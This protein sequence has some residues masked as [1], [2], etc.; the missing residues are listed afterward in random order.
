MTLSFDD[1]LTFCHS[2]PYSIWDET[3]NANLKH[4]KLFTPVFF[5]QIALKNLTYLKIS[6]AIAQYLYTSE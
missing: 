3:L 2:N 6:L 1:V 5:F 4:E